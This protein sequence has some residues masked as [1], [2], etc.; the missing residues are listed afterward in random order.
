M[1]SMECDPIAGVPASGGSPEVVPCP[2]AEAVGP[3][4]RVVRQVT[5][6]LVE[7]LGR[8]LPQL[9]ERLQAPDAEALRRIVGSPSSVLL[10]AECGGCIVGSLTLVWYDVPSGCKAWIEDVVVDAARRGAGIGEALVREALSRAAAVGVPRVML[11][12]SSARRAARALYRKVGFEEA[13][14]AVFAR[15]TD[16]I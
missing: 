5:P 16:R 12:S 15:K 13:E 3:C 11:T 7:A 6:D 1:A 8:L 4:I 14:T 9:S 10:V 2:D